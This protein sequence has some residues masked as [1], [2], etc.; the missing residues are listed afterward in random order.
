[1]LAE[2]ERLRRTIQELVENKDTLQDQEIQL[3][4][5]KLDSVLNEYNR[6]IGV[7]GGT[8]S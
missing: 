7:I 5:R 2:I 3:V 6:L 8:R 4:S 1:M